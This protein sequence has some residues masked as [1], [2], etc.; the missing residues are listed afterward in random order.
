MMVM[1]KTLLIF[2]SNFNKV[3]LIFYL[4]QFSSNFK[5]SVTHNIIHLITVRRKAMIYAVCD[6]K[7]LL[8]MSLLTTVFALSFY[9][10]FK[11]ELF[12][13][14]PLFLVIFSFLYK[15][16]ENAYNNHRINI[17][18]RENIGTNN[19]IKYCICN[20]KWQKK[21]STSKID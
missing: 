13:L 8:P 17:K 11:F 2:L 3:A 4:S 1:L 16:Y 7:N 14:L 9:F 18:Y 20:E 19:F 5:K 6:L 12:Q 21:K 15:Q 10:H